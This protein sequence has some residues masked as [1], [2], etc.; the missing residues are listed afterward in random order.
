MLEH[1]T[2]PLHSALIRLIPLVMADRKAGPPEDE[3]PPDFSGNPVDGDALIAA[4]DAL[5]ISVMI[6][7]THQRLLYVNAAF[8]RRTGYTFTE[9]RGRNPRLL[10]G[11]QTDPEARRAIREGI[12]RQTH[13]HQLILNYTKDGQPLWFDMHISPVFQDGALRYWIG[14]QED[15]S[16]RIAVQRET[17]WASAHD[18]LTGLRNRHG[19]E[20]QLQAH[21][22]GAMRRGESFAVVVL[23]LD[24]FKNVN[25]AH[26][27]AEGDRVLRSVAD[28]L[29]VHTRAGDQLYR[30]GGDEF[31]VVLACAGEN[32]AQSFALRLQ[33]TLAAVE[34]G[35][36]PVRASV[37][38]TLFPDDGQDMEALVRLADQ[39][40][41]RN[42]A[43]LKRRGNPE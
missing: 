40:M 38:M 33:E 21:M 5:D 36:L 17:E 11:P 35:N 25:D 10:Q 7:D 37:G 24:G 8:T 31:M 12:A 32:E 34:G 23:D 15:A 2:S 43:A 6:T 1:F 4:W 27:H 16:A 3:P 22:E 29:R 18:S 13:L 30:L 28:A 9:V 41:Y 39:R 42:K 19:L 14:V 26:G 20:A